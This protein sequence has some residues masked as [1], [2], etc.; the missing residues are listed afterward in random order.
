MAENYPQNPESEETINLAEYYHLLLLH[1]WT[2]LVSVVIL[3]A[4]S[5]WHNYRAVPIYRATS[6]LIIDKQS[7]RSPV[8]GQQTDYESYMSESMTFNTHFK[9][10]TSREVMKKVVK[11]LSLDQERSPYDQAGIH[12]PSVLKRFLSR[13]KKN[14]KMLIAGKERQEEEEPPVLDK[15]TRLAQG[16]SGM[17]QIEP[18]EETR[19]LQIHVLSPSPAFAKDVANATAEAY[20]D[21]N[22]ENRLESSQNTLTWLTDNLYEMKKKLEDAEKEF[23]AFKQEARLI[24]ME[25]SQQMIAQKIRDFN[26]AYIRARNER[27]EVESKLEQ[28]KKMATSRDD[29][30]HL[31]SL[32]E[33]ELIST[34]YSQLV[35]AEVELSS[36]SKVYKE[37]HPRVVQIRTKIE[38]TRKKLREE[39]NKEMA[40][41]QAQRSVLLSKEQVLQKTVDDF[42]QEA[43]DTG[44]KELRYSILNRNVEMNKNIYDSLLSRVKEADLTG[45]F[46][47][48]NIRITERALLP[49]SPVSPNKKRNLMLGLL[50]GLMLGVGL[51]FLRE[52]IDR[53]LRTEDDVRKYLD[54]PVLSVIPMA[55]QASG[56]GYYAPRSESSKQKQHG[57]SDKAGAA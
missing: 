15:A 46:D 57:S 41:L 43:M 50:L 21:F 14:I 42:E 34:L 40:N 49:G 1:K 35:D 11:D 8:T 23:Q 29:V 37:K 10:I 5:A 20:I 28:L 3:V 13:L 31:R 36:L 53:T 6:T 32:I 56:Q 19:L 47:V 16:L 48:S 17:I 55:E 2:I 4:L 52:Y 27:L 25:D 26:D 45:D 7:N 22:I 9:L 38:N 12:E 44:K 51:S 54:L 18:V 39:I 24:S 33:N 30:P